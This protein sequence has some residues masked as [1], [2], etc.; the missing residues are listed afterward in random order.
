LQVLFSSCPLDFSPPIDKPKIITFLNIKKPTS[1]STIYS[2]KTLKPLYHTNS[3][4]STKQTKKKGNKGTKLT[5]FQS[6]K[7]KEWLQRARQIQEGEIQWCRLSWYQGRNEENHGLL[8][9]DARLSLVLPF[10]LCFLRFLFS[11]S[12]YVFCLREQATG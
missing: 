1:I 3:I 9:F 5:Y 2:D 11:S 10:F 6:R 4:K 12:V 8:Q 7:D